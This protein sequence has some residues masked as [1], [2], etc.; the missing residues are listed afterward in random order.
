[1]NV[2]FVT[3]LVNRNPIIGTSVFRSSRVGEQIGLQGVNCT[4]KA[5]DVGMFALAGRSDA[6]LCG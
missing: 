5:P 4:L 2:R 3:R 6:P 1:M